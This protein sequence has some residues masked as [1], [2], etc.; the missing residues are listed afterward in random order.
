MT[1]LAIQVDIYSLGATLQHLLC[2][3]SPKPADLDCLTMMVLCTCTWSEQALLDELGD[4]ARQLIVAMKAHDPHERPTAKDA[5]DHPFFK[6]YPF[7]T[8]GTES[9]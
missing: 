1:L 8:N 2:G 6:Q 7:K 5:L 9:S 3:R 4:A